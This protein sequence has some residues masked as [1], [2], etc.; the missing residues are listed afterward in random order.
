MWWSVHGASGFSGSENQ[1]SICAGS[2]SGC[3]RLNT[4]GGG[5]GKGKNNANKISGWLI[6]HQFISNVKN[7][8]LRKFSEVLVG[9]AD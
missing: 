9:M 1:F 8:Y 2:W 7:L 6:L 5:K 4:I 3:T